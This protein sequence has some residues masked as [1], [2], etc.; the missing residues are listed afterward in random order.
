[1]T[2]QKTLLLASFINENEIPLFLERIQKN[3]KVKKEN[4]FFFKMLNGETFLT[5]KIYIDIERRINFKKEL[6][7][8]IQIHKK[9][10]TFFTINALNKL[11][12]EKSGL[13]GNLEHK[14]YKINWQEFDNKIIL[15][16]NE[17][18][19]ILPIERF[20]IK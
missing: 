1:V 16:K 19:E 2:Q 11:I 4:V 12:E 6:P 9:L 20:F 13:A 3:F 5:Y 17:N 18:L 7:K 10:N 15:I 14:E 8:T